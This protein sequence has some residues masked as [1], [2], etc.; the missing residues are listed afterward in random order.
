MLSAATDLRNGIGLRILDFGLARIAGEEDNYEATGALL[1]GTPAYMSPEQANGGPV[2][3]RSDTFSTA[4]IMYELLTG[5]RP[6]QLAQQIS[7][8]DDYV[9]YLASEDPLPT[10]KA[11]ELRPELPEDVDDIFA[12]GLARE[13]HMR[14]ATVEMFCDDMEVILRAHEPAM[15]KPTLIDKALQLMKRK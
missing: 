10:K 4:T 5:R 15:A 8:A 7:T 3:P 1:V 2:D 14:T 13:R 9:K 11:T 12:Q 6:I